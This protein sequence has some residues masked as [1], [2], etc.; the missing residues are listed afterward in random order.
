MDLA[1]PLATFNQI[2]QYLL[3]GWSKLYKF[4]KIIIALEWV[5]TRRKKGYL[6]HSR[7]R[8]LLVL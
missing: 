3:T 1:L 5:Q 4:E 8:P 7:L 6:C 2:L